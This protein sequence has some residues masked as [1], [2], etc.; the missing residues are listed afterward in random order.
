[1]RIATS[2]L[3][4][5]FGKYLKM[6]IDGTPIYV[7]KNNQPVAILKGLSDEERWFLREE[8]VEYKA[9]SRYS[10][11][12]FLEIA[13]RED[14][15]CQYE[16]IDGKI[17]MLAGPRV[18]HQK[19]VTRLISTIS[20]YFADKPCEPFVSPLDVKLYGEAECFEDNPNVVQPDILIMC[21]TE[22]IDENGIYQGIPDLVIEVLS[23]S[24]KSKDIIIKTQLYMT[25]G[26]KEYW[27]VDTEAQV[28]F[29]YHF[30]ERQLQDQWVF[31]MGEF[32]TSITFK[33]LTIDIDKLFLV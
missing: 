27:I 18:P 25:S 2:V 32:A 3:Q 7:E 33:G 26:I 29:I 15:T 17:Y 9:K 12:E 21:D 23:P 8:A 13:D 31:K 4:N 30:E 6:A 5:S 20:H 10:Y 16:L 22:N 19:A 14:N 28:L 11:A 24:T 1:M